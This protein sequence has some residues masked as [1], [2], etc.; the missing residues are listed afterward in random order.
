MKRPLTTVGF[1]LFAF[2]CTLFFICRTD[3]AFSVLCISA[4]IAVTTSVINRR[5]TVL[6]LLCGT[7]VLAC[8]LFFFSDTGR[9]KV[10]SLAGNNVYVE[11]TVSKPPLFDTEN[12]RHYAVCRLRTLDGKRAE[13]NLRL[14]FSAT[15]DEIDPDLLETGN[16]IS[17]TGRVYLPG[18]GYENAERCFYSENIFLGA[19]GAEGFS[20]KEPLL[21]DVSYYFGRLRSL[22]SEK[23]A[24]SFP[25]DVSAL[26]MGILTGDKDS[27]DGKVYD[28]FKASGTAHLMAVSGLHLSV[29]VAF[30]GLIIPSDGRFDKLR[31]I[32]IAAVIVFVM[33]L[34]GM[35]KSVTRA[36]LMSFMSVFASFFK[37]RSD[38]LNNL[39][40][41]VLIMILFDPYCV[42]SVSFQ[43]S[44]IST[45]SVLTLGKALMRRSDSFFGYRYFVPTKPKKL[46]KYLFDSACLCISVVIFTFPVM[47]Y[48]FGGISTV[49]LYTNLLVVP[50]ITP[51]MILGGICVLTSS[52]TFISY[53]LAVVVNCVAEYVLAVTRF[54]AGFENAFLSFEAANY[55]RYILA[56]VIITVFLAAVFKKNICNSIRNVL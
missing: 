36:G 41:A 24:V 18:M 26:L 4:F 35:S 15:K 9:G 31:F 44:A 16:R 52:V 50:V 45:L 37:T 56:A 11:A 7:M 1:T 8:L 38:S 51:L 28:D 29:W 47:V 48:S 6:L 3:V 33:L 34:A 5:V 46:M 25:D 55:G 20:I 2:I 14:S 49:T 43:L 21:R 17:F 42:L 54:F 19:Y 40:A 39:G 23:T 53:P 22:L 27:M 13:G 10:Q 30:V 12:A 32:L